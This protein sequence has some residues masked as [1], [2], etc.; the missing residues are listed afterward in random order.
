MN[1]VG[2]EDCKRIYE[3]INK[4]LSLWARNQG[5]LGR[6]NYCRC[7]CASLKFWKINNNKCLSYL[8]PV[9]KPRN[10]WTSGYSWHGY[11]S[12]KFKTI[13]KLNE[14][15]NTMNMASVLQGENPPPLVKDIHY[16][17][18]YHEVGLYIWLCYNDIVIEWVVP[19]LHTVLTWNE[20]LQ[21]GRKWTNQDAK[22]RRV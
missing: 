7:D 19:N 10:L 20:N 12:L 2:A 5:G 17:W 6:N 15:L 11:V 4:T 1:P 16:I 21:R 13:T 18:K 9:R 14:L 3:K 22:K 8:F